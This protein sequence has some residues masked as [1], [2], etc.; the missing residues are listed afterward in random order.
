MGESTPKLHH[1]Q[2]TGQH[3]RP[4]HSQSNLMP[5]KTHTNLQD[6][7]SLTTNSGT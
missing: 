2:M 3:Y 6:V 1:A 5:V 4:D 7:M